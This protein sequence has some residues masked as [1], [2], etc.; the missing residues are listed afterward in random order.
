[1]IIIQNKKEK[2]IDLIMTN[3]QILKAEQ[4]KMT[5]TKVGAIK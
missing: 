3:Y 5:N 2:E 1:M 4:M